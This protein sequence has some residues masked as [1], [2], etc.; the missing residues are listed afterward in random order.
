[1][2]L[3]K[4]KIRNIFS[5]GMSSEEQKRLLAQKLFKTMKSKNKSS[6][7]SSSN[8]KEMASENPS[9]SGH[10]TKTNDQQDL[11]K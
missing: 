11:T 10:S 5:T 3:K 6:S 1:M 7:G 8:L 9:T 2:R 4:R